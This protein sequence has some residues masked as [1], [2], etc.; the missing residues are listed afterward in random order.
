M[1]SKRQMLKDS[2]PEKRGICNPKEEMD[3]QTKRVYG[4]EMPTK[5][6]PASKETKQM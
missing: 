1:Y 2:G 3:K 5:T 6:T 4:C